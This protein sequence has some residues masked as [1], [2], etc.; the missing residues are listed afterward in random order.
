M[1]TRINLLKILLFISITVMTGAK[2]LRIMSYNIYGGRLANGVKLGNSIK[3][4]KPDFI[5]LQE[6]DKNTKRSKYRDITMDIAEELGYRYY[7]FQKARDFDSGEYGISFISK[8]PI[9]KIYSFELPSIGVEKRQVL[10]AEIGEKQF[11][12]KIM[13]MNTHL[14]FKS[15]IKKEELDY[16]MWISDMFKNEVKFL[17]G[18]LN[19][20]PTTSHYK[21]LMEEWNDSYM[22]GEKK[23]ERKMEDP[24][25]DYIL[26]GKSKELQA[27][28]SF[29]IN[30]DSQE[31]NK[32]S[33]HLP[34]MGI[35]NIKQKEENKKREIRIKLGGEDNME[36]VQTEG[37]E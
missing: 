27:K 20:L 21:K 31:W 36:I 9:D 28:D 34:Y 14:D 30:D 16:L 7:Y 37:K 18:D 12:Q 2:E 13:I 24:R 11:G 33:D 29:F 25:I 35:Y 15:E 5:S 17:S 23:E 32:L 1:K 26:G 3:K 6:V 8:Y 19:I 10:V 22:E 4:Y